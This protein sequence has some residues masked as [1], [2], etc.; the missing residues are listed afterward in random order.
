ML[1]GMKFPM[2]KEQIIE[3]ARKQNISNDIIEDSRNDS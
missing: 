2:R 1:K 3:S